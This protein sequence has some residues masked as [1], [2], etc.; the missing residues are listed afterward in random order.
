[1][2]KKYLPKSSESSAAEPARRVFS[3]PSLELHLSRSADQFECVQLDE[4]Q[5]FFGD[6]QQ[7]VDPRTGLAAFGPYNKSGAA[8]QAQLRVGIVGTSEEIEKSF[9]LLQ[10]ISGPVGQDPDVDG[11]LHPSFPGLNSSRPFSVDVVTQSSWQKSVSAQALHVAEKCGDPAAQFAMLSELFAAPVCALGKLEDAPNVVL[12]AAPAWVERDLLKAACAQILPTEIVRDGI[13]AEAEGAREDCA[14]QAWNLSVRLLYKAG[15][16]PWRLAVAE[17]D[18]CFAG[19]SFCRQQESASPNTWTSFAHMVTDLGRGFVLRGETFERT[20]DKEK[21]ET[22]HL[23]KDQAAELIS[24]IL[25][26]YRANAGSLPGKVVIHKSSPYS[27]AERLGFEH[28]LRGIERHALVSVMRSGVFFL[29]PG[30]EPLFRGMAM[31]FG[32][33]VGLVYTSGYVPFLRCYPGQQT[34][35]PFEITENW[36]SLTF[37]EAARDLLRLTKLNWNT[38]AFCAEVPVTLD[39]PGNAYGIFKILGLEYRVLEDRYLR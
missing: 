37:Q 18:T 19:I 14:T 31:P 24:R 34:P 20:P 6:G 11:I 16:T 35:H 38:S 26:V 28:S 25:E 4:P 9:A 13:S 5:L 3:S 22:P 12:C 17:G 21:V 36:G 23:G 27:D 15:L 33:K 1:M 8:N 39:L 10:K 2:A 32:E 30:R 29:R 7:C